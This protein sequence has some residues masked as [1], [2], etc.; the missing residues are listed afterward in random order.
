MGEVI[1]IQGVSVTL[2][3][4]PPK[5]EIENYGKKSKDQ[6]WI[7][8]DLPVFKGRDIDVWDGSEF[9]GDDDIPWEE[10]V[11]QETIKITGK[12]PHDLDKSG[13]PRK[14]AG[15]E[16]D[17]DYSMEVL[18]A[19]RSQ[20]IKRIKYG[21]WIYI[22]GKA[23]WLPGNYYFYLKYWWCGDCY[24]EFRYPDLELSWL[25][26]HVYRSPVW[27]GLI[28]ITIRGT[29]KSYY[30]GSLDYW[31]AITKKEARNG[32][33]SKNDNDAA[34]FFREKILIPVT[35]LPEFLRGI[36]TTMFLGDIVGNS[37][38]DFSPPARKDINIKLYNQMK[39]D[40]LR[41]FMD[42]RSSGEKAYDG[43]SLS[44]Y[45]MDE[46]G[47][48]S[49][50][51]CDVYER[52]NV[53]FNCL[54]RGNKKRGTAMLTSTVSRMTEG[55]KEAKKIW[56]NS[57][58]NNL[59]KNGRTTTGLIQYFRNDLEATYFDEWGFPE[60]DKARSYHDAERESRQHDQQ[61]L[62]TYKQQ[63]PRTV[64]EAFWITANKCIY[65]AEILLTAKDRL[66]NSE[67]K[68]VRKGDIT[69]KFRDVEAVWSD[70][71]VNGKWEVSFFPDD[72]NKVET[73]GSG[74]N[75]KFKPLCGHKRVMAF[76]PFAAASLADED[77]GSFGAAAVF[78]K[79]DFNTSEDFCNTFIADYLAR[80]GTPQECFED[81][82]TAAFFFGCPVLIETNKGDTM[83]Y[84]KQRGYRHGYEGNNDDFVMQRPE[85]T[86]TK[87]SGTPT[88][89]IY[90]T[91]GFI[92]QYTNTTST[93]IVEHGH[94]LKHLR[95]IDDWLV[96]D[97][98]K[99]K[100]FDMGVA[101]SMAL[102]A[103]EVNIKPQGKV[104]DIGSL[105]KTYNNTGSR[106]VANS[107]R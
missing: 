85:S 60:I 4:Q 8:T 7:R 9:K 13:N 29:G 81:I 83:Y 84:F 36:T 77:R 45:L 78:N 54:W 24:P 31:V 101:A 63:N 59:N 17:P 103:A 69:W 47:K 72:L 35:K 3:D 26:D 25:W 104:I 37:V 2:P 11:R 23:Y 64:E 33:Q 10:A 6:K 14:V 30:S 80:P 34:D 32:I 38:I 79:Y 87:F 71:S 53:V 43:Q 39:K 100:K 86:M 21:H 76:D 91:G 44:F 50:A 48:T 61:A 97:A 105:F 12:D 40:A 98:K 90:A 95:I 28:Y 56:D 88:D 57:N 67:R 62:V 107:R 49:P 58:L 74:D 22:K 18:D 42:F 66:T 92:E 96:F 19:F 27:L 65:N 5:H 73:L 102:V 93:H 82:I 46:F 94:K 55:G 20:E 52:W 99:T 51:E 89:G 41:S 75:K 1:N 68:F 106:S 16:P 15:V 70:N